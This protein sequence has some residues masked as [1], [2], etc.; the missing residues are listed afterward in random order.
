[1]A[2]DDNAVEGGFA[3]LGDGSHLDETS[4]SK[5]LNYE[6]VSPEQV[7]AQ[8][9][10]RRE[11]E[12]AKRKERAAKRSPI[13]SVARVAVTAV[14]L[15][16]AVGSVAYVAGTADSFDKQVQANT[17]RL[18]DI[19]AQMSGLD[20]DARVKVNASTVTNNITLARERGEK[21]TQIQNDMA[22]TRITRDMDDAQGEAI[23]QEYAV[24]VDNMRSYIAR[25]SMT[26]GDL[27]PQQRWISPV[28]LV[29][30][31]NPDIMYEAQDLK[32]EQYRWTM[33]DTQ[34]V[35]NSNNT[36]PVIWTSNFVGGDDDGQLIAWMTA[37]FDPETGMF[38]DF[39]FGM[40]PFGARLLDSTQSLE[41]QDFNNDVTKREK[42]RRELEKLR[43]VQEQQTSDAGKAGAV[44][45]PKAPSTSSDTGSSSAKPPS[46]APADQAP[47]ANEKAGE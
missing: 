16:T 37:L 28:A 24:Q 1:M 25:E 6:H 10:R 39:K 5:K 8:L 26:G 17:Q 11:V 20:N 46:Q 23:T 38:S 14:T 32:P 22:K 47:G 43:A 15:L 36:V 3:P 40:S 31:D 35:D 7:K 30:S 44:A 33:H 18:N 13:F 19:N 41:Q 2:K 27:A 42:A 45:G 12:R 21:I 34:T 29:K 4:S 9:E